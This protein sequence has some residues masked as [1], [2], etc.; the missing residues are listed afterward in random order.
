MVWQRAARPSSVKRRRDRGGRVAQVG[1][2]LA[3]DE[4]DEVVHKSGTYPL[5]Q[6]SSDLAISSSGAAHS[7]ATFSPTARGQTAKLVG[8]SAR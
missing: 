5:S 3:G 6:S 4:V 8:S 1:G 7:R 2:E